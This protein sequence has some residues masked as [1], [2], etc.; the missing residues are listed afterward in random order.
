MIL[1]YTVT[2]SD[3]GEKVLTILK[4]R[5]HCSGTMVKRLKANNTIY[6]NGTP[7]YSNI[8]VNSGDVVSVAILEH[9]INEKV[10]PQDIPIEVL[11]EDDYILELSDSDLGGK[12]VLIEI[13][14]SEES[15]Q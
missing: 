15:Y 9:R 2:E 14:Y 11:Y 13:P 12:K 5:L 7:T 10:V 8:Q 1:K 3:S 4:R 6:L